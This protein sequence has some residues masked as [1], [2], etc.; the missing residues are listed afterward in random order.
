MPPDLNQATQMANQASDLAGEI[1]KGLP[2]LAVMWYMLKDLKVTV[3]TIVNKVNSL[4]LK[5]A[6][7]HNHVKLDHTNEKLLEV[8]KDTKE[9][10]DKIKDRLVLLETQMPKIWAQVGNR[11]EDIKL[12]N[13]RE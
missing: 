10:H 2:I 8:K 4:E 7:D 11:P 1:L 12:R 13:G 9:E 3:G 6:S 5:I